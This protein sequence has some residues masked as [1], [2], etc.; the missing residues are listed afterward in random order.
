ME[1]TDLTLYIISI[2]LMIVFILYILI[3]NN[4]ETKKKKAEE[5]KKESEIHILSNI[6]EK[7]FDNEKL[8]TIVLNYLAAGHISR[9]WYI[10]E[11]ALCITHTYFESCIKPSAELFAVQLEQYDCSNLDKLDINKDIELVLRSRLIIREKNMY[12]SILDNYNNE[13]TEISEFED[14]FDTLVNQK[15]IKINDI[16]DK[17][18]YYLHLMAFYIFAY[19]GTRILYIKRVNDIIESTNTDKNLSDTEII[20]HL[21]NNGIDE[22]DIVLVL[23]LKD[24]DEPTVNKE[25]LL[26]TH[27]LLIDDKE[28][29]NK[30]KSVINDINEKRKIE[31]LSNFNSSAKKYR[32]EDVDI[33]SGAQFEHFIS[34]LF[35]AMGYNTYITPPSGDQGVDVIAKK[36][37]AKIAIQAKCYSSTVGNHAIMEAVAG[38]KYY[39]ANKVMVVTNNFFTKS[40]QDLAKSNNV[41]LWNRTELVNKIKE[42]F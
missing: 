21:Y 4:I 37:A 22:D 25:N 15:V 26:N 18:S 19:L 38:A 23:Q 13:K 17:E 6:Y 35:E 3:A 14:L 29:L 24:E 1:L 2:V 40:A 11:Y 20:E 39:N 8:C 41:T 32:I 27:T 36:G 9:L 7:Y 10:L 28:Y 16:N 12:E 42:L 31:K 34:E 33:M 30:I 5:K